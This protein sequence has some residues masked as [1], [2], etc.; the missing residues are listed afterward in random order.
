MIDEV[1]NQVKEQI[2]TMFNKYKHLVEGWEKK[3]LI[4]M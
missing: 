2:Q 1:Q 4:F 3:E